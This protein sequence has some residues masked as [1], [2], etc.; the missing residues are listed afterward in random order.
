MGRT[1]KKDAK[2]L[3]N[4]F[5]NVSH[6]STESRTASIV[7]VAYFVVLLTVMFTTWGAIFWNQ[8]SGKYLCHTVFAQFGDEVVPMLGRF[9]DCFVFTANLSVDEWVTETA[10]MEEPCWHTVSNRSVG[11][12]LLPLIMST[13]HALGS[14]HLISPKILTYWRLLLPNG[15]LETQKCASFLCLSTF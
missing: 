1:L 6:L 8:A 11:H 10:E 3:S 7:T 14:R 2:K 12:F 13:T 9:Q 15:L 5:Y 4:T